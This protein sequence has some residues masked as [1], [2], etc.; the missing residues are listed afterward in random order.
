M[1]TFFSLQECSFDRFDNYIHDNVIFY[2]DFGEFLSVDPCLSSKGN[3]QPASWAT[4]VTD[5]RD[6]PLA[7]DCFSCDCFREDIFDEIESLSNCEETFA[8]SLVCEPEQI[9]IRQ[10]CKGLIERVVTFCQSQSV[11]RR[12]CLFHKAVK[13]RDRRICSLLEGERGMSSCLLLCKLADLG[14][15]S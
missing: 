8:E 13:Y 10:L 7:G 4:Y 11:H 9:K 6:F 14:I 15:A 2:S 5:W 1:Q 12:D 3:E